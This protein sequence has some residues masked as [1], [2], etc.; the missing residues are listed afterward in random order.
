M[1]DCVSVVVVVSVSVTLA[2]ITYGVPQGSV[3]EPLKFSVYMLPL[4]HMVLLFIVM[5]MIP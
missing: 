4:A 2:L 1:V 5:L 3:L